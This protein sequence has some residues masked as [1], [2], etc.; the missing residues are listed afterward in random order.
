MFEVLREIRPDE[1][2]AVVAG[3][4]TLF[5]VMSGHLLIETARDAMFLANIPASQLPFLYLSIAGISLAMSRVQSWVADLVREQRALIGWLVAA[6]VATACLWLVLDELGRL[7]FYLVYIFPAVVSTVTLIQFWVLLGDRLTVGNAKR[8][9]VLLGA[10]AG[11]GAMAGSGGAAWLSSVTPDSGLLLAGAGIW[12]VTPLGAVWMIRNLPDE[13]STEGDSADAENF[14]ANLRRV[15]SDEYARHIVVLVVLVPVASTFADYLFKSLAAEHIE[16]STLGTFFGSVYLALNFLSVLVQLFAVRISVRQLTI[17]GSLAVLPA[18]MTLGG[19]A[20]AAGLP[21]LAAIGVKVVDGG[22][23]H[24]LFETAE[25]LLF[26]PLTD[27]MRSRLKTVAEV[28]GKRGGQAVASLGLLGLLALGAGPTTLG[29][30]LAACGAAAALAAVALRGPYVELFRSR[31]RDERIDYLFDYPDLDADSL[32]AL[33]SRL[34]STDDAEVLAALDMLI[35]EGRTNAIPALI[36]YHP[37]EPVVQRALEAFVDAGVDAVVPV[38]ER[39]EH[40]ASPP[41]HASLLSARTALEPDRETLI[42]H[43][44][45]S[46]DLVQSTAAFNLIARGWKDRSELD[47]DLEELIDEGLPIEKRTLAFAIGTAEAA[48]F[49]PQLVKLLDDPDETVRRAAITA[50]TRLGKEACLKPLRWRLGHRRI[51]QDLVEAFYEFGDPGR[52]FLQESL[53]DESLPRSVRWQIPRALGR[54]G[55]PEAAR[56]MA[57]RLPEEP[58]G[59][60]RA[61][62][63]RQLER[64]RLVDEDLALPDEALEESLEQMVERAYRFTDWRHRLEQ[65]TDSASQSAP[66]YRLLAQYLEDKTSH[67]VD[68]VLRV[69]GLLYPGRDLARARRGIES[70]D[71]VAYASGLEL[72]EAI[73]PAR[74]KEAVLGLVDDREPAARVRAGSDFLDR[75]GAPDR[76]TLLGRFV[77]TRSDGLALLAARYAREAGATEVVED[78]R[79]AKAWALGEI[80]GEIDAAIEALEARGRKSAE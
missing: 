65:V 17:S 30:L 48:E 10:G 6:A 5:G 11:V 27:T 33:V 23:R 70:D 61:R 34:S 4:L 51:R 56:A 71:R 46:S 7:G 25:E 73:V 63:V 52:E 31:L 68:L 26:V 72:L 2:R 28:G 44:D 13:K 9:Y 1:R 22:L 20:I 38:I 36:L 78:L 40:E 77:E 62:L 54:F 21:F 41:L 39:I 29:L 58:D 18:L 3:F 49:I 12:A 53:S 42:E 8:L 60:V 76:A 67:S 55:D 50:M 47:V 59:M 74:W 32:E 43:L 15:W 66:S 45:A 79:A 19:V 35:G 37:S 14:V 69:I 16:A 24:S 80:R 75:G 64:L 57:D